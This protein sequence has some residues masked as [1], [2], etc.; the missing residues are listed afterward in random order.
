[1]DNQFV[2]VTGFDLN[3]FLGKWYEIARLPTSFERNLGHVTATYSLKKEGRVEVLNE[4][5]DI[6]S[7][8]SSKAVGKAKIA[9]QPDIGFLKVSFF[10]PFYGDYIILE[11]DKEGYEYALIASSHKYLWILSRTP[12]LKKDILERLVN[13]AKELGFKTELLYYTPQSTGDSGR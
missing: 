4:G 3:R 1:M 10:G 9:K 11:L 2:P 5:K 12:E 8:K 6:W 13:R 7:G